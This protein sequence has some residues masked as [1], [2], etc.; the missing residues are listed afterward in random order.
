MIASLY[1]I[2]TT[3][4]ITI[5]ILISILLIIFIWR[6]RSKPSSSNTPTRKHKTDLH[7]WFYSDDPAD[8]YD[9]M[10]MD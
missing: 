3:I 4:A 6:K 2:H 5:F 7:S 9:I 10:E 1:S 8:F